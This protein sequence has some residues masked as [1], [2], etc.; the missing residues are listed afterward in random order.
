[1]PSS[2]DPHSHRQRARSAV[3]VRWVVR[4]AVQPER[5]GLYR[6]DLEHSGGSPGIIGETFLDCV[7]IRRLDHMQGLLTVA[8]WA[9]QDDKAV[10]DECVHKCRVLI[11]CLLVPDLTRRVPAWPV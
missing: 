8:D 11:P 5:P 1:M 3:S 4:A 7:L 10:I 6:A 9:T 2:F